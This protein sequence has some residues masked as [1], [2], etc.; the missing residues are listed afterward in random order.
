MNTSTQPFEDIKKFMH[1]GKIP[2]VEGLS[3]FALGYILMVSNLVELDKD[4]VIIREGE[5]EADFMYLIYDGELGIYKDDTMLITSQGNECVGE[6]ISLDV[7]HHRRATVK[8]QSHKAVLLQIPFKKI[9][10]LENVLPEDHVRLNN[11]ILNIMWE[12]IRNIDS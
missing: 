10:L 3:E 6:M 7:H 2:L 4:T 9:A 1:S 8:V 12:R 5:S 11:N